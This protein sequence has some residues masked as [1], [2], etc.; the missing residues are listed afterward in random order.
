MPDLNSAPPAKP[1]PMTADGGDATSTLRTP[2]ARRGSP[3]AGWVRGRCLVPACTKAE[4]GGRL[5]P[6]H[7]RAVSDDVRSDL[8]SVGVLLEAELRVAV[9]DRLY[10]SVVGVG[11]VHRLVIAANLGRQL[12][13]RENVH[14]IN[15]RRWDNSL[16]NLELWVS[17]QPSGQRP[18]DLARFARAILGQYGTEAERSLYDQEKSSA[19][20]GGPKS[21]FKRGVA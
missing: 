10:V 3:P 13:S 21:A 12:T 15:G 16:A 7:Q 14:H 18:D 1:R 6:T 9:N 4:L 17:A 19:K 2:L 20:P 11:L 5:C 8:A